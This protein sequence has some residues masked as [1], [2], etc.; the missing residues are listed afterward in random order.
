MSTLKERLEIAMRGPPKVSS[1]D[2]ARACGIRPPSVSAWISGD[3]KSIKGDNLLNAARALNVRPEWLSKGIL[4][5]RPGEASALLDPQAVSV[6]YSTI[7]KIAK[8][9]G[10]KYDLV[11][12][13]AWFVQMY[14]LCSALPAMSSMLEREAFSSKLATLYAGASRHDGRGD[15]VPTTGDGKGEVARKIPGKAKT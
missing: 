3:T 13:P 5:M 14:E 2:L 12:D 10:T 15:A 4:P 7:L 9:E 1:A 11:K 6:T 8:N